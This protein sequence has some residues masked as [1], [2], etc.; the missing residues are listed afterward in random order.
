MQDLYAWKYGKHIVNRQHTLPNKYLSLIVMVRRESE[1]SWWMHS[2]VRWWRSM[3]ISKGLHDSIQR[4]FDFCEIEILF[5]IWGTHVPIFLWTLELKTKE[6]IL[7]CQN[8]LPMNTSLAWSIN[9]DLRE[10]APKE[11]SHFAICFMHESQI[12]PKYFNWCTIHSASIPT[13]KL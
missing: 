6:Q 5:M 3:H 2:L 13:G 8:N 11:K 7:E 4:H 1:L 9:A 12:T 10:H